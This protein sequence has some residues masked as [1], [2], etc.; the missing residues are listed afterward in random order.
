MQKS[1]RKREIRHIITPEKFVFTLCT[2]DYVGKHNR[3]AVLIGFHYLPQI[4]E[5]Y[6][7][8]TSLDCS[9]VLSPV[10]TFYRSYA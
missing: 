3:H 1:I 6:R 9:L 8:V 7:L 10:L 2:R 4:R 5:I